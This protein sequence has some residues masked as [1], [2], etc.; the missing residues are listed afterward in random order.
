MWFVERVL[1]FIDNRRWHALVNNP[2]SEAV[3]DAMIARDDVAQEAGDEGM[4]L[5]VL[6]AEWDRQHGVQH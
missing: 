6:L 2:K 3:F 1:D 5:D 4:S